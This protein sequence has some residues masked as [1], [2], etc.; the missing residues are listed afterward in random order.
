ML[1]VSYSSLMSRNRRSAEMMARGIRPPS[2]IASCVTAFFIP[3]ILFH[4]THILIQGLPLIVELGDNKFYFF[5]YRC[6]MFYGLV[7]PY[8]RT[9]NLREKGALCQTINR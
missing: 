5:I 9:Q 2:I 4:D 7:M 6:I 3:L 1:H 8:G